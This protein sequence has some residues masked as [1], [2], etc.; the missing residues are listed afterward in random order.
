[1]K[2]YIQKNPIVSLIVLIVVILVIGAIVRSVS[3]GNNVPS[4]VDINAVSTST[5][6]TSSVP[7]ASITQATLAYSVY[8]ATTTYSQNQQIPIIISVLNLTDKPQTLSFQNG[9]QGDYT[10][11][12]FDMLKHTTCLPAPSSFIV[13]PHEIKQVKVV[14]YPTVYKIPVG[15]YTL[16]ASIVGYGGMSTQVTITQ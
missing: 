11:G 15:K 7:E 1:M 12:D 9:C 10:I 4:P 2:N 3:H 14:H 5:T 8:L 6:A 16:R 13:P